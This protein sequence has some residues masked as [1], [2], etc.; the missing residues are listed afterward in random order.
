MGKFAQQLEEVAILVS[1][2]EV[3]LVPVPVSLVALTPERRGASL[4]E[5]T[6]RRTAMLIHSDYG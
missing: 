3:C 2:A 4:Q 5:T 1:R 6:L